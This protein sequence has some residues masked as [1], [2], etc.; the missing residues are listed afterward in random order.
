MGRGDQNSAI[1]RIRRLEAENAML[2]QRGE[3]VQVGWHCAHGF[4]VRQHHAD[5]CKTRDGM[6]GV[7]GPLYRR[8]VSRDQTGRDANE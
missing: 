4:T 7:I 6:S 2:R 3:Y 8:V 1:E 5:T